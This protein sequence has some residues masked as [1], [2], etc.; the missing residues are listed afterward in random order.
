M[1]KTLKGSMTDLTDEIKDL[2]RDMRKLG[3]GAL[4][5]GIGQLVS[6]ADEANQASLSLGLDIR[7]QST[8]SSKFAGIIGGAAFALRQDLS[9]LQLGLRDN[10]K[11][12]VRLSA[13]TKLVGRD[14]R[15]LQRGMALAATELG[16]NNEAL[17]SLAETTFESSMR[18]GTAADSIVAGIVN[19]TG[20]MGALLITGGDTL[21]QTEQFAILG[22]ILGPRFDKQI[23]VF[24]DILGN[25]D[26][27][28]NITRA[29]ALGI[30]DL[31]T[32]VLRGNATVGD[33]LKGIL[34][35][36]DRVGDAIGQDPR[37]IKFKFGGIID[38]KTMAELKRLGIGIDNLGAGILEAIADPNVEMSTIQSL[39]NEVTNPFQ[40]F[41]DKTLPKILKFGN[42]II[43]GLQILAGLGLAK[44][45]GVLVT[46]VNVKL[47]ALL[48]TGILI[49]KVIESL[50]T[51][52]PEKTASM[53]STVISTWWGQATTFFKDL[54]EKKTV[55]NLGNAF[56]LRLQIGLMHALNINRLQFRTFMG[57]TVGQLIKELDKIESGISTVAAN[58]KKEETAKFA[59]KTQTRLADFVTLTQSMLDETM[60]QF[61]GYSS[62]EERK[63]GEADRRNDEVIDVLMRI[64]ANLQKSPMAGARLGYPGAGN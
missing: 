53:V 43:F 12:L 17:G 41:L 3:L 11:E 64:D 10:S 40:A 9:L 28:N 52:G 19:L 46:A 37:L 5:V 14:S 51:Q 16:L 31:Q 47:V 56:G 62:I 39:V 34:T 15:G 13:F 58:T 25:M 26:D 20:K 29:Q 45:L 35:S 49:W 42:E 54:W 30:F 21:A 22:A 32:S 63:E 23:A 4:T 38:L 44:L 6:R 27:L 24:A 36:S 7:K 55:Q 1:A 57:K 18:F 2:G 60:R 61:L 59:E 8:Q 33:L 48:G 50:I